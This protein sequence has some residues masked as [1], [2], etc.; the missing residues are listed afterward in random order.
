MIKRSRSCYKIKYDKVIVYSPYFLC[1]SCSSLIYEQ[2][3]VLFVHFSVH[4]RAQDT[5]AAIETHL[6]D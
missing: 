4:L 5:M 1:A 3:S 6:Q 2:F